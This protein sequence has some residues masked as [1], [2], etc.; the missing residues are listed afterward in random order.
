MRRRPP[1]SRRSICTPPGTCGSATTGR[2]RRRCST[3]PGRRI[4]D[5][6]GKHQARQHA[7]RVIGWIRARGVDGDLARGGAARGAQPAGER[8]RRRRGDPGAG[9][10]GRVARGRGR[11]GLSRPAAARRGAGRS[12]RRAARKTRCANCGKSQPPQRSWGGVVVIRRRATEG[13]EASGR[14][15]PQNRLR[16]LRKSKPL[17]LEGSGRGRLA[18]MISATIKALM[19]LL[20]ARHSSGASCHLIGARASRPLRSRAA[21]RRLQ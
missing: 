17:R 18:K 16:K 8:R 4:G 2:M 1:S 5:R 15:P 12:I 11:G 3:A 20:G 19:S 7:R 13:S 10:G 6:Q 9:A 21:G 14:V